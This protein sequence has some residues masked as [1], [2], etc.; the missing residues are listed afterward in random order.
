MR[1]FRRSRSGTLGST[2]AFREKVF[3]PVN[4]RHRDAVPRQPGDT[5]RFLEN[6]DEVLPGSDDLAVTDRY[7]LV[8]V[9]L[10][11]FG[12]ALGP[13]GVEYAL[14]FLVAQARRPLRRQ[15]FV[16]PLPF[17]FAEA[18]RGR[19]VG[20]RTARFLLAHGRSPWGLNPS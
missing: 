19:R 14:P 8:L 15:R 18:E 3:G 2:S 11:H 1:S 16:V 12:V 13:V 17:F 10:L 20:G 6:L 4:R 7:D 9:L 5:L